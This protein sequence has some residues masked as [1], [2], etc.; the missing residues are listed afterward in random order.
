VPIAVQLMYA[1]VCE[2][3]PDQQGLPISDGNNSRWVTCA[4]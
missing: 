2:N 4:V 3:Q 1:I